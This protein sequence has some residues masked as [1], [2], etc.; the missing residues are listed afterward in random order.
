MSQRMLEKFLGTCTLHQSISGVNGSGATISS[1]GP[2]NERR[3]E[4][5]DGGSS[6]PK[7]VPQNIYPKPT[8]CDFL[9]PGF[10]PLA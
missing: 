4:Q 10:C 3:N 5:N 6:E 2:R 1:D 7:P 8:K 9:G